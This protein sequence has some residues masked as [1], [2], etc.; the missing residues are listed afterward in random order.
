M[1][2]RTGR[3]NV[4]I[5]KNQILKRKRNQEDSN[6]DLPEFMEELIG[7]FIERVKFGQLD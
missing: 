7:L 4:R 5:F 1:C 3:S 6:I 2:P